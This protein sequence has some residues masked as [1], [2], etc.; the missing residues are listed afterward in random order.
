M[1]LPCADSIRTIATIGVDILSL[2]GSLR[3]R[4]ECAQVSQQADI[5][6][7]ELQAWL[8]N[9]HAVKVSIGCGLSYQEQ[10]KAVARPRSH[11]QLTLR[12]PR[13]GGFFLPET[14]AE[15]CDPPRANMPTTVSVTID[16]A[17]R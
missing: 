9:D 14:S 2:R 12:R 11:R 5:T 3:I 7:V 8:A 17:P 15:D 1:R 16:L 13:R 4:L 10:I 6:L